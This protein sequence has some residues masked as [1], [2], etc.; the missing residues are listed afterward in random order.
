LLSPGDFRDLVSGRRRGIR[1]SLL[2]AG[3]SAIEVP[4]RAAMQFRNRRYDMARAQ[5][6]RVSVPVISIGNLTLGGTGKTP[7]VEWLVRW[8]T[9][10]GVSAGIVSRGYGSRAGQ[11]NDEA[12]E[13]AE[14]LPGVPHVAD[15]DRVRGAQRAI[16]E[17]GCQ[18][19][20]LDDGFQHRRLAR[21]F[22]LVLIDALEPF[23]FEHV[24]PRGT[25]REPLNGWRRAQALLLTRADQVDESTRQAI[26]RR[27]FSIAPHAV[28][29]E[30]S[31][32]PFALQTS[33]GRQLRLDTAHG[34][35]LAAFCGI[36]NP[37]GFRRALAHLEYQ[38]LGFREL[39][40]HF[41]YPQSEVERLAAWAASAQAELV[42]CTHKD[43]VKV[44][45]RWPGPSPLAAVSS[46]LRLERGQDALE[47]ALEPLVQ[48]AL[49]AA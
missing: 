40:D 24:F 3:L 11:P 42:L 19:I 2:R 43:L 4:Y 44:G 49:S 22:D 6:H 41:A 16:E 12:L 27:A 14:K 38:V 20:V 35:P 15:P 32:Q 21:D 29:A 28:W 26:R 10:R 8:L 30:A 9:S 39:A 37:A 7:A 45:P 33:D 1:A 25:L 23:G 13:L 18:M 31:Y 34:K 47:S 36:G 5:I 46:Q 48:R 17:F